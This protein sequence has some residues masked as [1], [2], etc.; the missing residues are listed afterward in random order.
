MPNRRL[1]RAD[2]TS[3]TRKRNAQLFVPVT[4]VNVRAAP[5]ADVETLDALVEI[6]K[7]YET[8]IL[9]LAHGEHSEYL[10]WDGGMMFRHRTHPA[11]PT[12][13]DAAL[14]QLRRSHDAGRPTA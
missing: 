5:V 3:R 7:K 12:S 8:M 2:D 10:L 9:E 14:A 6:A 11:E 4:A 1:R 13:H